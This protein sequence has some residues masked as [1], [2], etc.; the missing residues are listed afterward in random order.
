VKVAETLAVKLAV[1]LHEP[2]T[3]AEGVCDA[4]DVSLLED[5]DDADAEE[6]PLLVAVLLPL[7][8]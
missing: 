1:P 2:V 4:V 6:E 5:D 7:A 8:L 3:L